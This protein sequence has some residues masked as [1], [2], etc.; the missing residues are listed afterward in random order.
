MTA[1]HQTKSNATQKFLIIIMSK[2][3]P[4]FWFLN[5]KFAFR[6]RSQKQEKYIMGNYDI[7]F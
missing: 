5:A 6:A 1:E 3:V 2:G 4:C 7:N